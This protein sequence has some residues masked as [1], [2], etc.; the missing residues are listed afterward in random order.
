MPTSDDE[1]ILGA[2]NRAKSALNKGK[3]DIGIGLEGHIKDTKY[4]MFL[5]NWVASVSRETQ[6]IGSSGTL[7]LPETIADQVRKGKELGPVM[8][9][10]V[11]V[12]NTKQ[13]QGAVGI[14]TK[15]L[16]PRT[17]MFERAVLF[18]LAKF[19]NPESYK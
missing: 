8:D 4:G 3:A 2:I 14:L 19:Y 15:G 17:K 1:A 7:L 5:S 13:K 10:F 18:S 12:E 11:G 6:C 9:K 16:I